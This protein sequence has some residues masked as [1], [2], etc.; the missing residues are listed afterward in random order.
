[1]LLVPEPLAALVLARDEFS[2]DEFLTSDK[3]QGVF[4][5]L[6]FMNVLL[7]YTL[8]GPLALFRA[9]CLLLCVECLSRRH[10]DGE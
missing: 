7:V 1:M 4:E 5:Q 6:H 9:R 3:D 10:R 8:R 2:R